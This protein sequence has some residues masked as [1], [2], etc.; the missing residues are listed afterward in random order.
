MRTLNY[1]LA[2][3]PI[4]VLSLLALSVYTLFPYNKINNKI[5]TKEKG[6]K[7]K[8]KLL[9]EGTAPAELYFDVAIDHY[10]NQGNGSATYPMRYLIDTTNF[11]P[12]T[13]CILFYA[14]NEGD[15]WTFWDNSGFITTTL[16]VELKAMVVFAE[17]R[18]FGLS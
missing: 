3:Y 12:V 16:A 9:K 13:G 15:V 17:H 10:T 6:L 4:L 11:D 1:K 8:E 14:G 7:V 2:R 18:Y 5:F